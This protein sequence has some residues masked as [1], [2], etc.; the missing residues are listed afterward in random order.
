MC[1]YLDTID[2]E[3]TM[4]NTYRKEDYDPI[5]RQSLMM[6]NVLIVSKDRLH[7]LLSTEMYRIS[8]FNADSALR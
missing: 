6:K 3:Q 2:M 7:E 8:L 5:L 1:A 4:L